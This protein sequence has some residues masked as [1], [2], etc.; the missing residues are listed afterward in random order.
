MPAGIQSCR[1]A[2][3]SLY[4]TLLLCSHAAAGHV[5][6]CTSPP[7]TAAALVARGVSVRPV[8]DS[9]PSICPTNFSA[10][11]ECTRARRAAI[12]PAVKAAAAAQGSHRKRRAPTGSPPIRKVQTQW[13]DLDPP[14][15]LASAS[16]L[17]SY[18]EP[19]RR[20]RS[21]MH[22]PGPCTWPCSNRSPSRRST[23]LAANSKECSALRL[24]S[25]PLP[26]RLGSAQ[27]PP[28]HKGPPPPRQEAPPLLLGSEAYSS[29][30]ATMELKRSRERWCLATH[31][32]KR[33]T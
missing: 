28:R 7:G 25:W 26:P 30:P 3:R 17:A 24:A 4:S 21:Q 6:F 32:R 14:P 15:Y 10:R 22:C 8:R 20:P 31:R 12:C 11:R 9:G 13:L 29:T 1:F 33:A 16:P 19:R 5:H 2:L 18:W 23:S 27:A